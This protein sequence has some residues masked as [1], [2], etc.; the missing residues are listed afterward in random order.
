MEAAGMTDTQLYLAIGVP[1]VVNMLF[2]GMFFLWLR[3]D[4]SEVR[5]DLKIL[6]G[7]VYD[8]ESRVS[9]IEDKLGIQ[10]H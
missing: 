9:R 5:A 3:A 6:T 7:K 1:L 4:V 2:N 8:L 10:P